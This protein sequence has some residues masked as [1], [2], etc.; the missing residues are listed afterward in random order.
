MPDRRIEQA[1]DASIELAIGDVVQDDLVS[2]PII[3]WMARAHSVIPPW[4]SYARDTYLRDFWKRSSH[5]ATMMYTAQNLLV[6]TPMRVEAKNPNI[7]AHVEQAEFITEILMKSSE[8]GETLYS[9]KKKFSEDYL[10]TDNGG[11]LEIIGNGSPD[12]PIMGL[13]LAV[14]H[15]DSQACYRTRNPHYPVVYH[16]PEDGKAYKLHRSRVVPMNQMPSPEA[17]RNGVGYSAV[18]R[19]LQLAQHLYDIYIFKQ[20]KLGSRPIS[21]ILV[22]AGFRGSHIMQAV[23]KANEAMDNMNLTRYARVVGIGSDDVNASLDKINLNDFDPFDEATSINLAMYAMSAAFGIPIQE[24]WPEVSRSGHAGDIQESRQRGK[25]PAEFNDEL[26]LILGQRYLPSHLKIVSD[27]RDDY[28]DERRAVNQDIRARNRERDL[29]DGAITV[30]VAREQM[31]EAG[32]ISRYQFIDMELDDGRLSDGSPVAA[33]F[34]TEEEPYRTLLDIGIE[35]PTNIAEHDKE[36]VQKAVELAKIEVYKIMLAVSSDRKKSKF[37]ECIAAL[38]WLSSEYEE[39][40]SSSIP[41]QL[42]PYSG[43]AGEAQQGDDEEGEDGEQSGEQQ[44]NGEP[45]SE[46]VSKPASGR[47]PNASRSGTVSPPPHEGKELKQNEQYERMLESARK[48][49]KETL[50]K[51]DV[52]TSTLKKILAAFLVN[53]YM[54]AASIE[55]ESMLTTED[56]KAIDRQIELFEES[57]DQIIERHKSGED[58][59]PTANRMASQVARVYWVGKMSSGSK[60]ERWTWVVGATKESCSDCQANNGVTKTKEEWM[61][62]GQLPQSSALECGGFNCQCMLV[63]E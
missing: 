40:A 32:D 5:L 41:T 17:R 21:A 46:R 14:R 49:F 47:T 55:N 25:L 45:E 44:A 28:Q 26:G 34:Y 30:R 1:I 23:A 20:E 36:E 16:D 22:G 15:L 11:F 48:R 38:D 31:L 61:S 37:K 50:E 63:Q 54:E 52:N 9:A 42:L 10:A 43:S 56:R 4:W 58:M 57:A 24:V 53:A 13:P 29:G 8:F 60:N 27:W 6:N 18:S 33:L 12:G 39:E 2:G 62:S 3:P 19:S 7:T 59:E 51:D 35:D